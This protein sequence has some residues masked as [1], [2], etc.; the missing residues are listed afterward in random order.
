MKATRIYALFALLVIAAGS[1]LQA[2]ELQDVYISDKEIWNMIYLNDDVFLAI[3][4]TSAIHK[5]KDD[6]TVL[7]SQ[8]LFGNDTVNYIGHSEL[9]RN[10]NGNPVFFPKSVNFF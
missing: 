1:Q 6:G 2:Q 7:A 8:V 3:E 10:Y 9:I 4:G 5:I